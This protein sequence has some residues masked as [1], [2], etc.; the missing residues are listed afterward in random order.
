MAR[1]APSIGSRIAPPRF[2]AFVLIAAV[3]G[4]G[5]IVAQGWAR[6]T[7]VAFDIAAIVF[8]LSALPLLRASPAGMRDTAL[9]NDANRLMMLA[10]TAAT[11]LAV[12]AA[13]A[14]ELGAP[15]R[16]G[17]GEVLLIV[18][19]LILAWLFANGM[20]ALHYAHI[21]YLTDEDG[22]DRRG[23]DVPGTDEPDYRDFLYFAFTLGMT[24]QTSDVTVT[25]RAIRGVVL[26]H[27]LL[28]FVF[29]L[30]II[31]FTINVIGG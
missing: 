17:G 14:V 29:N 12:L 23:I 21:Y 6:G 31:A 28:A 22:G 4:A 13:V 11:T 27:S 26:A 25:D 24:F 2:I 5:A 8:L 19:T 10:I 3:A 18:G 1:P 20:F 7:M 15:G 30:G 9:A 16:L